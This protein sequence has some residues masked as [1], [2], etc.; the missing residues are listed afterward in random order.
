MPTHGDEGMHSLEFQNIELK[1]DILIQKYSQ[2]LQE[3]RLL[4]EQ[5]Q[6]LSCQHELLSKKNKLAVLKIK[7]V[8][9][10]LRDEVHEH[11]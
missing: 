10:K 5:L 11:V 2:L 6:Q 7:H 8:I 9:G 3:N 1:L 4:R